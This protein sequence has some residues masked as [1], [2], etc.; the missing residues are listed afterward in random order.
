FIDYLEG[1]RK[2]HQQVTC[3]KHIDKDY[4]ETLASDLAYM[5]LRSQFKSKNRWMVDPNLMSDKDILKRFVEENIW[6]TPVII[7]EYGHKWHLLPL[8]QCFEVPDM[9]EPSLIY[10]DKSH[11]MKRSEIRSHILARPGTPIPSKKVLN[12]LLNKE[13]TNWPEFLRKVN[14]NGLDE[15]DLVIGLKEKEREIKIYG[16]FFSLMSWELREYFVV[17]E[18]LIKKYYVPLFYGLTMA[19]NLTTVM[20]KMMESSNG[21]GLNDYSQ[22]SIAN[23]IDYEKWNN[24]QRKDSTFPVFKVMGQFLGYPM[25]IAR[26][27]ELF[28]K[29]F[30]YH[31]GRGD[32]LKVEGNTI[33]NNSDAMTCW[34][35]Q[36]GGLEGLRQKGW[37]ILNLLVIRRESASRNTQ[38][39]C[40]AQGDNQVICTQYKMQKYRTDDELRSNIQRIVDNNDRILEKIEEGTKKLG[41][42]INQDETMR[43]ADYLNYGKIPVF[44]GNVMNL[45]NKKWSRVNCVTNDQIPTLANVMSSVSTNALTVAHFSDS[46]INVMYH[47]NFLGNFVRILLERHNPALRGSVQQFLKTKKNALNSR[48]YKIATLYLDPSLGGVCGT[49]LTRFLIRQ[50][51]DPVT[52]S[53][54][55][56]KMV[57]QGTSDPGLK[58]LMSTMGH[59]AIKVSDMTDYNKLIEDPLSLNIP[60][61]VSSMTMIK[62]K[63]KENLISYG[64]SIKN[65][66]VRDAVNHM[67]EEEAGFKDFLTSIRPVFGRFISEYMSA[68]FMG[69]TNNLVGLFQNSRTIRNVF[70]KKLSRELDHII[71]KGEQISYLTVLRFDPD[72]CT[73]N[74]WKCSASHADDLRNT[75]WGTKIVGATIPHPAEMVSRVYRNNGDCPACASDGEDRL[76]IS[77][78]IPDGLKDFWS[79]RGPYPAY[80]G[81]KTSETTSLLQ[82]WERE[83]N[84]DFMK[85]PANLRKVI[86]WMVDPDSTIAESIYQNLLAM[87]GEEWD[88]VVTGFKRTG[89]ALHRFSC[90]RQSSGG[91][92]AQSP[93][94]LTRM[95]T[96]T[97]TLQDIGS[98]NYDF[99]FQSCILY[100]QITAGE[101][102]HDDGTPGFY[103]FHIGC[104][105]CLR[106]IEE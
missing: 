27:H 48:N 44:R 15:D 39:K 72:S 26:T 76:Y 99:M 35:G 81:S 97:S 49:A 77:L 38:V 90:S 52:E 68:T 22:I 102:H 58:A 80:L 14:E 34:N 82:P 84:V 86:G 59:P 25:L 105:N 29:S 91:F 74:M 46:P 95:V 17:T 9:I 20:R 85:R 87:T 103:H 37:S 61:G 101:K 96:T 3:P 53:L 93:V 16:R 4:A 43:S 89:S 40:L 57:Y 66:M 79:S 13:S 73:D 75:S 32:L 65:E 55:F 62:D 28:E 5:V 12:T 23:H 63:I 36:A 33:V 6:P 50:F 21:Q 45:E 54:T 30:I 92:T 42:I 69:I 67:S 51:P 31:S 106:Q 70:S 7:E 88:R 83:C 18:Y 41:L 11:S 56:L 104:K 71:I 10:A 8:I 2:L 100:C 60:R 78:V 19:D 24:H 98:T 47:F 64:P 1:L 94:K